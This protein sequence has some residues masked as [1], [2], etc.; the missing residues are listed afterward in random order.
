VLKCI[1]NGTFGVACVRAGA[2]W[3]M[4]GLQGLA[5]VLVQGM[6]V[7]M[8]CVSV[9]VVVVMMMMLMMTMMMCRLW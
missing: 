8:V 3:L 2:F 1:D 4:R 5:H 9:F 7:C 6:Q